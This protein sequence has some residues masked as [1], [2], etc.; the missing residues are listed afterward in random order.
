MGVTFGDIFGSFEMETGKAI[1]GNAADDYV[2][3]K[4]VPDPQIQSDW[5]Q[6]NTSSLDYIKNKPSVGSGT[7]TS[8]GLV[9]TDLAV[10]GSPITNS[11]SITANLSAT[12]V[13]A[14]TYSGVTVDTKGRVSAGTT[15]SFASPSRSVNT[16]FQISTT[17]DA[18]VSY[19]VDISTT[20]SLSGGAVGTVYLEYADDSGFTTNVKEVA[21]TT[22]GNTGTL[23]V[24]LALTQS[25]SA[26]LGG[27]IP[28][29]KY[30]RLRTS[31]TTG[32]PTYGT[33][34][35]QEVLL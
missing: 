6:T 30:S 29:A 27:I 23:V 20:V 2:E 32:T 31:N 15:R 4:T 34:V 7:V 8:I 21:H 10:S 25:A 11:G 19:T 35:V 3:N 16:A 5:N 12:G 18:A 1:V 26:Q 33:P 28:A 22:N 17:R 14:G 24:G 13:S 9:S